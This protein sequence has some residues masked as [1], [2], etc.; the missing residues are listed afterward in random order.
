[1]MNEFDDQLRSFVAE[2]VASVAQ[3]ELILI[4]H[5][6]PERRWTAAEAART[7]ALSPEMTGQIL[8]ELCRQGL[9]EVSAS[10]E[11]SYRYAPA[12]DA[13]HLMIGRLADCYQQRRV[14]LIQLI[15]GKPADKLRSFAD[16]FD[17]RKRKENE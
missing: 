7:F 4:M 13:A 3:L 2:H 11:P 12:S 17:L 6:E 14:S 10:E 15:Y 5:R 16:A 8:A 9:V 1:M